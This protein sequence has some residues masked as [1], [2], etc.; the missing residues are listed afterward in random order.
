MVDIQRMI[1]LSRKS[2][3]TVKTPTRMMEITTTTV[4]PLSSSTEGQVHLRNSSRVSRT[5]VRKRVRLPVAQR[6]PKTIPMA[7]VQRIIGRYSFMFVWRRG[8][9]SNP[10]WPL[11]QSGF[12]DRRVRPLCHPS[13]SR[14]RGLVGPKLARR[15]GLEPPT[16]GFGDRYSTNCAN[17]VFI[18]TLR[19]W[20]FVESQRENGGPG[21]SPVHSSLGKCVVIRRPRPHGRRRSSGHPREWRTVGPFPL[22]QGR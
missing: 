9:D 7:A 3:A 16:N 14:E 18:A 17:A 21:W 2:I 5:Y 11:S 4:E 22:P 20:L 15:E 1:P 12:Q 6:M 19:A 8:R 13:A 10:R